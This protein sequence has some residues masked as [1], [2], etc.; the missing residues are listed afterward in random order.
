MKKLKRHTMTNSTI[1][2]RNGSLPPLLPPVHLQMQSKLNTNTNAA[3]DR[4]GNYALPPAMTTT[5]PSAII[6]STRLLGE[7][8]VVIASGDGFE[9][10]AAKNVVAFILGEIEFYDGVSKWSPDDVNC[11]KL[12]VE[13]SM[14]AG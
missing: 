10:L 6:R 2:K 3:P 4:S 9:H 11:E 1:R 14:R 12:T 8:E 7:A 13:A 5:L